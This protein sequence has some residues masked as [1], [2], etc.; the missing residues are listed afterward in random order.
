MHID[1]SAARRDIM[2]TT[3]KP[4]NGFS[5]PQPP[6]A[7]PPKHVKYTLGMS[8]GA[9]DVDQDFAWLAERDRW[10]ARDVIGYGTVNG[11][12]VTT[13]VTTEGVRV[14]VSCGT[15]V[16]PRGDLVRV[17]PRQCALLH[18]WIEA[19]RDAVL[20][21][22]GGSPTS[23]VSLYLVLCYDTCETDKRPV[24]GEPCRSEEDMMAASRVADSF[25]L[26]FR[27][28][29]PAHAEERAVREF[30]R[31]LGDTV[32][33]S[34]GSTERPLEDFLALVRT[35]S[36]SA[37]EPLSF[38]TVSSSER[39]VVNRSQ[40]EEYLR[41]ALRVWATE[42]RP[43]VHSEFRANSGCNGEVSAYAPEPENCL[44]LARV[45]AA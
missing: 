15:A 10:F 32:A 18:K 14:N 3:V 12:H 5:A 35:A 7:D 17:K 8:L 26:E 42:M 9:D 34:D 45:D 16:T 11:L 36:P 37:P 23:D 28:E 44:L 38:D 20:E 27:L 2:T 41:A 19:N 39:F 1:I 4:S 21:R 33:I 40:A 29:P 13:G 22:A 24:P 6:P 31:W 43:R 25:R 30:V